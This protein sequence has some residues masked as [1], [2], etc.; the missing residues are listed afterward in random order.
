METAFH[1]WINKEI[2]TFSSCLTFFGVKYTYKLLFV[3]DRILI[4]V[5]FLVIAIN[6]VVESTKA[7]KK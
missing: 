1:R 2:E 5:C 7:R 4:E 3:V 6:T